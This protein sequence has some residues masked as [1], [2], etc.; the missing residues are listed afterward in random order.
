MK[1]AARIVL[2][3]AML[4][5]PAVLSFGESGL[6]R[7]LSGIA[8]G[9]LFPVGAFNDHVSQNGFGLGLYYGKR[10]GNGPFFFGL[11]LS[12]NIYGYVHRHEYLEGIPEVRVDVDTLNNIGQGLLFVRLQPRTGKV[13]TYIEGLA[14]ISYIWTETSISGHEYPWN[15]IS[16]DT[17]FDAVTVTAGAGTGVSIRLNRSRVRESGRRRADIYLDFKVRYMAGGRAKYLKQGS[18]VVEGDQFTYT[19]EQSATSFITAQAAI[20]WLF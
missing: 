15:E 20:S 9:G 4:L 17:N 10:A 16:S 3:A 13:V 8:P 18:I 5:V 12:L 11:E 7:T 19:Y 2:S 1:T 6:P 14:G